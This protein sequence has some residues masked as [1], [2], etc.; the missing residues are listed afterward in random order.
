MYAYDFY[1]S[2]IVF[3]VSTGKFLHI[4][5][6]VYNNQIILKDELIFFLSLV[7]H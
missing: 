5:S 2:K 7:I 1:I 6:E 4:G 3:L